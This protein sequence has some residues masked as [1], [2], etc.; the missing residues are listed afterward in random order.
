MLSW[1]NLDRSGNPADPLECRHGL[2][3]C[4]WGDAVED[5]AGECGGSAQEDA[6]G[7]CGGDATDLLSA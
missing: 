4:L 2:C 3:G 5:C 6:C 7:D 1:W